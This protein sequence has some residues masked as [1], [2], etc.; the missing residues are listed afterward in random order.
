MNTELMQSN[1]NRIWLVIISLVISFVIGMFIGSASNIYDKVIGGEKVEI[2]EIIDLYSK[3]RSEKVSFDQF[4]EVWNKI[5]EK[6]VGQPVDEVALFYGALEGLVSGLDDP[7]SVYMP[8][9]D[10]EAFARDLAGEFQGI[11][12][13]VGLRDGLLIIV[14]PLQGS[15]AGA[16]G[17]KAGDKIFAIDGVDSSPLTLEE[18]VLK[19]RGEK[20]TPVVLTIS[21]DGYDQIEDI[22]IIR[23]IIN[24]PTVYWE[25]K[26]DTVVYMRINY[27]NGTTW[28]EFD[29]AVREIIT[30]RPTGIILDLRSNPGGYLETSIDVASEWV[31][32]GVIVSEGNLIEEKNIY[33]SRGRHRLAGIKTIVLVDEGTASGSEIV[34]GALQDHDV[35]TIVGAQTF[36]KGSVQDL[37]VLPDGSALKLTIAKWFT[38]DNRGIDGEGIAPDVIIEEMF[39]EILDDVGDVVDYNDVGILRALEMLNK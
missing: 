28:D 5:V 9:T 17:L 2:S 26:T 25:R 7:Y 35:A 20:G 37:E 24:V 32:S 27:F 29:K 30:D 22:T 23:D 19:I 4:W 13:E 36:G 3:T 8:P 31:E 16:A 12:A 39:T 38:P 34:A 18:A 1:K 33:Q 11:G 6:H 14:S 10:A 21:H 15:P